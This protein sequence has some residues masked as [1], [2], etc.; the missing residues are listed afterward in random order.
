ML[1]FQLPL[2]PEILLSLRGNRVMVNTITGDFSG[3]TT[4]NAV[5]DEDIQIYKLGACTLS[6]LSSMLAFYRCSLLP[7]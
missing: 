4:E 5:L 7:S 2:I 3:C 1:L 6:R